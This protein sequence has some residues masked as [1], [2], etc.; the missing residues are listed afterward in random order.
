MHWTNL[1]MGRR[2]IEEVYSGGEDTLK[3][4]VQGEK[5]HLRSLFRGRRYIEK[6]H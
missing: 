6:V 3:K 4:S 1:F 5:I 2:Y